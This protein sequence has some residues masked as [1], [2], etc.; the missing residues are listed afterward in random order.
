MTIDNIVAL[1]SSVGFP[2]VACIYMA[3]KINKT[4]DK[5]TDTIANNTNVITNLISKFDK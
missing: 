3:T 4:L 1:I 5:L 2:I